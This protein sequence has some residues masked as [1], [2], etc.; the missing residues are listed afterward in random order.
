M[1]NEVLDTTK[2][3]AEKIASDFIVIGGGYDDVEA[4]PALIARIESALEA[5]RERVC[6]A[7]RTTIRAKYD[8]K[9]PEFNDGVSAALD[10]VGDAEFGAAIREGE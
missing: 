8:L 9:R 4:P 5:E 1:G 7:L 3:I 6:D 2:Q 10:A